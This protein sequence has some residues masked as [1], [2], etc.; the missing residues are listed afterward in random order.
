MMLLLLRLWPVLIPLV[1]YSLWM[2][3]KRGKARKVGADLPRFFKDG[4]W[5]WAVVASLATGLV[6]L[7]VVGLSH[8]SSTGNYVPPYMEDGRIVPGRIEP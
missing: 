5:F 7:L 2:F 4:P 8:D 6:M 3:H 1:I